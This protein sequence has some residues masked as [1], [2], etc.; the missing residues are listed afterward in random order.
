MQEILEVL[1]NI[2]FNWHVALLNFINFL[3]ILF[4]LNK[5]FF[6]KINKIVTTRD[7]KIRAGLI[8]AEE[9]GRKLHKTESDSQDIIRNARAE[10]QVIIASARTKGEAVARDISL[11]AEHD[12]EVLKD[13]LKSD[14]ANATDKANADVA[15][16][17]PE[18]VKIVLL[19]VLGDNLNIEI[20]KSYIKSLITKKV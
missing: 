15:M 16:R 1:G 7:N 3:I 8:H 2:G 12:S 5:F 14:I 9:A 17:T 4:I 10:G 11:K 6:K 20:D 13:K 18:L 19:Q